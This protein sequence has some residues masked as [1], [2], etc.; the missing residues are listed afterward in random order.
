M[1]AHVAEGHAEDVDRAVAAARQA[2]DHG[3][4]PKMTA[5]VFYLIIASSF[6]NCDF[7][8]VCKFMIFGSFSMNLQLNPLLFFSFCLF[9]IL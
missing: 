1:I 5:Y 3:P 4:W 6:L 8:T 2:F 9:V 7:S